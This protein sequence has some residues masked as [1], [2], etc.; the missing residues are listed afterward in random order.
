M[1]VVDGGKVMPLAAAIAQG[2][3]PGDAGSGC[4]DPAELRTRILGDPDGPHRRERDAD[5]STEG[6]HLLELRELHD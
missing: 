2:D 6:A 1:V 5:V 3:N 4:P